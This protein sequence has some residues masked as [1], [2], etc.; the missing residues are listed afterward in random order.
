MDYC[1]ITPSRGGDRP[2]FFQFCVRQ[3][4]KFTGGQK[5]YIM[6]DRP[7]SEAKDLIPRVKKGIE[8]AKR[9]GFTHVF[10]VE[11]DDFYCKEYFEQ[12]LDFDFFGY[13]DTTYY[14]LRNRT[15]GVVK[16]PGRSSLFTTAFKIE[17]LDGFVWPA[18]TNVFLD[19]ALWDFARK[20]KKKVKLLK[21]NPCLGIKHN[22][23]VVGG[24]GHRMKLRN[25]DYDLRYLRSRVDEEAFEFYRTLMLTL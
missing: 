15:Y 1:T 5:N 21:N 16:H 2:K 17:A 20:T 24:K 3:L 8:L 14:N 6:N 11:D 23:G 10:I 4:T 18:D 25:T 12:A 22:I 7:I 13:E 19:I 9:D